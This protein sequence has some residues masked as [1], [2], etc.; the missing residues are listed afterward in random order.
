MSPST[1]ENEAGAAPSMCKGPEARESRECGEQRCPGQLE[2]TRKGLGCT[3]RELGRSQVPEGPAVFQGLWN[4]CQRKR[5]GK[6]KT[7]QRQKRRGQP[8]SGQ[9]SITEEAIAEKQQQRRKRPHFSLPMSPS[10]QGGPP[11]AGCGV[12]L[13]RRPEGGRKQLRSQTDL[14]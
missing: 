9:L 13:Q 4:G 10:G 1:G 2:E 12:R 7:G 8:R 11:L 3:W 14:D 5:T 6:D